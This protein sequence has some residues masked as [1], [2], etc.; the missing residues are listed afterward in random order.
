MKARAATVVEGPVAEVEALFYD[1]RRWPAWVD[2]FGGVS[3]ITGEWPARG[4]ALDWTSKPGG[5]GAVRERVVAYA[6][7]EGQE[8]DVEDER[9]VGTQTVAFTEGERGAVEVALTLDYR[10]KERNPLTPLVDF[11]FVRRAM[12]ASLQRSLTRFARERAAD[13]ELQ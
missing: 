2:G 7:A 8:L 6:P 1:E 10:L 11:F 9:L 3:S 13:A 4:A 5:R 12:A